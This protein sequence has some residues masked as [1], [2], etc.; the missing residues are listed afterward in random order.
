MAA[1]PNLPK[2]QERLSQDTISTYKNPESGRE[3]A[4]KSGLNT[5]KNRE[6]QIRRDNDEIKNFKVGIKDIDEAIYYYFNE[7][8]RPQVKQNGK[9][10]NVPLV[11]GSPERWSAVQ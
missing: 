3:I 8:L 11:Y 1:K 2:D 9:I 10:I 4:P 6:N 5:D 7:V